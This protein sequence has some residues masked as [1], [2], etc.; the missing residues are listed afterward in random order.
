MNTLDLQKGSHIVAT[1]SSKGS[2]TGQ[3]IEIGLLFFV[4]RA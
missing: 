4:C 3:E 1:L 2:P